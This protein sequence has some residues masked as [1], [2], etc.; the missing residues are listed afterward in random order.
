VAAAASAAAAAAKVVAQRNAARADNG[1]QYTNNRKFLTLVP[2]IVFLFAA[3][4]TRW[5]ASPLFFN[6]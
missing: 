2:L 3:N 6:L 5:Q 1:R 4:D